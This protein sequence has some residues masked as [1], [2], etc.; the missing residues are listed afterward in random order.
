MGGGIPAGVAAAM[1]LPGGGGGIPGAA[2]G[3]GDIG[4]AMPTA[5]AEGT[6]A[7]TEFVAADGVCDAAVVPLAARCDPADEL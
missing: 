7:L 3:A 5:G 2:M 1:L 6:V 4:A